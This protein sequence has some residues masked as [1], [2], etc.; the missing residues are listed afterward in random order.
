MIS[1]FP[2]LL[3]ASHDKNYNYWAV[4]QVCGVDFFRFCR[5]F[6][7]Q[8][9]EIHRLKA[10]NGF[11]YTFKGVS[12]FLSTPRYWKYSAVPL[13]LLLLLYAA[14]GYAVWL[15]WG[16][17]SGWLPDP[18]NWVKY[19]AWLATTL[20]FLAATFLI[21]ASAVVAGL[22]AN[23]LFEAFGCLVFDQ[24]SAAFMRDFYGVSSTRQTLAAN[25]HCA[26]TALCY[27]VGTMFFVLIGCVVGLI[28]P[29][30]GFLAIPAITGYRFGR[31]YLWSPLLVSGCLGERRE[32]LAGNFGT[33]WQFGFT[34]SLLLSIPFAGLLF[35]PGFVIAGS[36]IFREK[37]LRGGEA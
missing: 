6:P 16:R 12:L 35:S 19:L 7:L 14:V 24:L 23:T 3:F 30:F 5:Y 26:L 18:E 33:V 22:L 9:C 21:I 34:A 28:V 20:R 17:I 37:L 13:L 32:L 11:G 29:Y 8:N 25:A 10:M 1:T 27:A 15:A 31:S 4:F 2:C 36:M